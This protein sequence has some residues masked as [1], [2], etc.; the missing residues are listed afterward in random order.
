MEVLLGERV[1][2]WEVVDGY[3]REWADSWKGVGRVVRASIVLR[4]WMFVGLMI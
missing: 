3:H 1:K 4:R 2:A